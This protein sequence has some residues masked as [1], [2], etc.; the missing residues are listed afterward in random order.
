MPVRVSIEAGVSFGWE[1]WVG[2]E[3]TSIG[4]DQYGASAAA[5]RCWT[6]TAARTYPRLDAFSKAPTSAS[7]SSIPS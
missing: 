6:G 1:K 3:G 4:V 7:N 2:D 5:G